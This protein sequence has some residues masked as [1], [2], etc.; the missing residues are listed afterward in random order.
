VSILAE[1]GGDDKRKYRKLQEMLGRLSPP[2]YACHDL[3]QG[4]LGQ[5][6]D[7]PRLL[8]Q[9]G[10]LRVIDHEEIVVEWTDTE[11]PQIL[12]QEF[13]REAVSFSLGLVGRQ[14]LKLKG[15]AELVELPAAAIVRSSDG[16]TVSERLATP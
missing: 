2:G 4:I 12:L 9:H 6:D 8:Q 3:L 13:S 11:V 14:L 10:G 7:G 1:S 5:L 15:L 16:T